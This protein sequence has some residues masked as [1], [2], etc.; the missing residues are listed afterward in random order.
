MMRPV[1]MSAGLPQLRVKPDAWS[2][3]M[4]FGLLLS[5]LPH[6]DESRVQYDAMLSLH[7]CR[8]HHRFATFWHSLKAVLS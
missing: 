5:K 4:I 2:N 6:V 8:S 3:I 7:P 1:S